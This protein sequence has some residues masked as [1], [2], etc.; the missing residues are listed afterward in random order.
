MTDR[1]EMRLR[2]H[3]LEK[4]V[5]RALREG[6][7]FQTVMRTGAHEMLLAV[8]AKDADRVLVMAEEYRMDLTVVSE[9]GRPLWRRRFRERGTLLLGIALGIM[10][11]VSFTARIWRVEAVSLDGMADEEMLKAIERHAAE[12]GA[13]PGALR[14]ALDSDAL[15]MDIQARW[16]GLT[17]VSVR[18]NGVYLMVEIASE[19]PAPE[20]YDISA[21]RDLVAARDAVIVHVEPLAGMAQVRA[22]DTVR[23]GQVLIRGEERI[24]TDVT[25]GIR[26]LG[27]VV[28]RVWFSAECRLPLEER[29][30][31]RTGNARVSSELRLGAWSVRLTDAEDFLC[32]QTEEEILP[33]GGLFLPLR[34]VR[35]VRYEARERSVPH[36]A[37]ALRAQGEAWALELARAKLPGGAEETG[38]WVDFTE[39]N[40]MLTAK[41]TI[42]AQMNIAVGR[43]EAADEE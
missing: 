32:Q 18:L 8:S 43:A 17:H 2:G 22:G 13:G 12:W 21:G 24:D 3:M 5:G 39:D 15:A 29:I 9:A 30:V 25:R 1:V 40:G 37:A 31:E 34:I 38:C 20:I 14:A 6:V 7:S 35:T 42:E 19:E 33:I 41:A 4:F 36:D 23:R 28:G 26:A 11:T 10:L 27:E 16:P